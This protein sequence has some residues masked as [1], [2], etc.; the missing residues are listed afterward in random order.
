M[1]KTA[2]TGERGETA[3]AE[4]LK[5]RGF[6]ITERNYRSRYGEI[7]I[8]AENREY[9]LFVEVKTRKEGVAVAPRAA[10]DYHKQKR[11]ALTAAI[12]LSKCESELQPR[13]DVA[14]VF[15]CGTDGRKEFK[16][17]YIE[18]AFCPEVVL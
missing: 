1:R 11:I 13:F 15:A 9:I 7:D 2:V 12:Y 17:N 14:E 5:K 10:V 16:V 8:I 4:Y 18:N 3:V 6:I